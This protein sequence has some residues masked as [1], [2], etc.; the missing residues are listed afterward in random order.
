MYGAELRIHPHMRFRYY[1]ISLLRRGEPG[2]TRDTHGTTGTVF[3][4]FW[5]EVAKLCSR[6]LR[7]QHVLM[8]GA[9]LGG[10]VAAFTPHGSHTHTAEI[11]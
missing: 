10:K 11:A 8:Q 4:L 1:V 5:D 2:H 7:S 3:E 6:T 9:K